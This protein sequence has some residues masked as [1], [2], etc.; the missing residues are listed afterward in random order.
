MIKLI[1]SYDSP[2]STTPIVEFT[3]PDEATLDEVLDAF[4]NFLRSTGYCFGGAVTIESE[5]VEE[6]PDCDAASRSRDDIFFSWGDD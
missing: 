3:I 1:S 6:I 5:K 2:D 4:T